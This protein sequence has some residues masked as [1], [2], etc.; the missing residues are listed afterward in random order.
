MWVLI[1]IILL[2]LPLLLL[3]IC[4]T[5]FIYSLKRKE[6]YYSIVFFI[7]TLASIGLIAIIIDGRW[8]FF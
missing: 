4:S 8:M 5:S 6:Y 2:A 7:F 3:F 1:F